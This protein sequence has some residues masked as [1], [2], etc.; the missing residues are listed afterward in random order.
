VGERVSLS[1]HLHDGEVAAGSGEGV[2]RITADMTHASSIGQ[3]TQGRSASIIPP[4]TPAPVSHSYVP[5]AAVRDERLDAR[6]E[7]YSVVANEV[8]VRD[9]LFALAR[10]ARLNVDIHPGL[11]GYVTM[12]AV[13]QTLPQILNR[14]ARQTSMRYELDGDNLAVMPDTPFLRH[15]RV[16]YVNM[17]RS[18]H[19][20]VASSTQIAAGVGNVDSGAALSIGG[21]LPG[22]G[23]V[24]S[25]RV[26]N[27]SRNRFWESLEEGVRNI[28]R[29][30][31]RIAGFV[32][33]E[34]PA[35]TLQGEASS[36]ADSASGRRAAQIGGMAGSRTP[37]PVYPQFREA[38]SV[39]VHPET[40]MLTI[41][42]TGRQHARIQE[43]IE[44]VARAAQ[45]QVMIEATIVEVALSDSY[46]QGIEW[47]RVWREG[48]KRFGVT[49]MSGNA[50]VGHFASTPFTLGFTKLAGTDNTL[51]ATLNLLESFGTTQVLSSPR[52]SV[53]NNQT[54]LLKVVENV[55]YFNIKADVTAGNTNSN[56]VV[57]YSSTPQTV[58][59]GLVMTVTPQISEQGS[60]ILNVRPTISSIAGMV[61]DPNPDIPAHI[62]NE[63]PQIRTREI[64]SVLRLESGEIAVLGGLMEDRLDKSNGQVPLL[65]RIPV[66]GEAF[67]A[68]QESGRKSEL[69]I[70]LR[71]VV[72]RQASLAGDFAALQGR[73]PDNAFWADGQAATAAKGSALPFPVSRDKPGAVE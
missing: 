41:R 57:A 37:Q 44:Q 42:A 66:I 14:I 73:L 7:T 23:N 62:A 20:E 36:R 70:F 39:I 24:S 51:L 55:V 32:D 4:D 21:V 33:Q 22:A 71:P 58:S 31:D 1:G 16:D 47:E 15:Y 17:A 60:V 13:R 38:A 6:Q 63:V 12:N 3:Q 19:G 72:I 5:P 25:T 30:T 49:P 26:E 34:E 43:F 35:V 18:V 52:L 67:S 48:Q 9:L 11:A 56:P 40:G 50:A 64:E 59:V 69:V 10:D 8:P 28:L 53:L 54:A 65:G 61:K 29:E 27:I 2:S 46:Q 68:R 45:R